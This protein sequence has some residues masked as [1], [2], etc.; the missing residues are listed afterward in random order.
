MLAGLVLLILVHLLY[1]FLAYSRL[2]LSHLLGVGLGLLFLMCGFYA[3]TAY[4]VL[5]R[6]WRRH[7]R[8]QPEISGTPK[9][10]HT[11]DGIPGDPLNVG[12]VGTEEEVV[13]AM[14]KAG[15]L[16]AD[17]AS[18]QT[19]LGIVKSV[20]L[21]HPDPTAPVSNLYIGERKQ[22]LAFEK[23]EGVDVKKRHHVRFWQAPGHEVEGRTLWIGAATFDR[24][25]RISLYTGQILHRIDP[26][27]D[28][29]RDKLVSD[30]SDA[31][32]VEKVFQVTGLGVTLKGRNGEGDWYYTDGQ[33][34]IAELRS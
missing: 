32:M 6:I 20:L 33:I 31:G 22:D 16:P 23:P 2:S 1:G 21:H 12:L 9:V 4:W 7:Y 34:V 25:Y 8:R 10:T 5:P 30:L 11:R 15:W 28:A 24:S 13:R 29:E 18:F 17:P 3:F 14:L 19:V 26:E 27:V